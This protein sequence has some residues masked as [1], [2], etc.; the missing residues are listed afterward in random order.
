MLGLSSGG[1]S[2]A[3][4]AD[5]HHEAA[6][7]RATR[8]LD[9]LV[10]PDCAGSFQ[11]RGSGDRSRDCTGCGRTFDFEERIPRLFWS[12]DSGNPEDVTKAVKAFYEETPFPNYDDLDSSASLRRKAEQGIFARMLD[13]Q[14]SADAAV[15][16]VGCGTGQL[17]NYL[18]MRSGRTIFGADAS[19][20]SL[21]LGEEFRLRSS[22][23]NV[24]FVQMN[25]FEPVF[26]PDTFD[27]VIC[28]GV[29][30]HTGDP[31]RGF[32][33]I[34]RLVK[35]GG[36]IVIGLYN[37]LGRIPAHLRRYMFRFSGG[38]LRFLDPRLRDA[39]L[40]E[41]RKQA[42]YMD[43][44]R[45]PHESSHTFGEVMGWFDRAG[46]ELTYSI[47]RAGVF[48]SISPTDRLFNAHPR[49]SRPGRLLK[50]LGMLVSGGKEGGFFTMIG[51]RLD[52][53][54]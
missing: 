21:R 5:T 10:C 47:P 11:E 4:T 54:A 31:C 35:P 44:Y 38:R 25:L 2:G 13:D 48:E 16:E 20:S 36:A 41:T 12:S 29:L 24:A 7:K 27:L 3:V 32:Q 22:L 45:N 15:L 26:R 37:R 34:A 6:A 49:G 33:S 23:E 52:R 51:R 14:I 39:S 8:S 30:H 42:W 53:A 1:G 28:N 19:L 50:Q 43:Q 46:I 17:S 18:G 40:S 9:Y